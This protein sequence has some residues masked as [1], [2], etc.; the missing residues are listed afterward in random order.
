MKG[1]SI[2]AIGR[3]PIEE[4]VSIYYELTDKLG[5]EY[6]QLAVG[7]KCNVEYLDG[8]NTP[9][10]LHDSCLYEGD[11]RMFVSLLEDTNYDRYKES[12]DRH[13]ISYMGIHPPLKKDCTER[14]V[15]EGLQYMS[16]RLGVPV[17]VEIMP[18]SEYWMSENS[19]VP[20]VPI[21]LD[22]S[23]VNLWAEGNLSR[24]SWIIS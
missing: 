19:M 1:L 17:A 5:V 18:S 14:E 6:L 16:K 4:C 3:R 8:L 21:I 7:S 23:H 9:F 20:G 24:A 2:T 22:I 10:T 13:Y 11:S 12:I 15:R